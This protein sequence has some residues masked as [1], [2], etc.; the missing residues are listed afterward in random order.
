MVPWGQESG[1]RWRNRI[2]GALE[3]PKDIIVGLPKVT[4]VGYLQVTVENHR[5]IVEFSSQRVRVAAGEGVVE[6]RG[7]DL[8]LRCVLP[9]EIILDGHIEAVAFES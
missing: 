1:R 6:I 3:L 2:A 9:D 4:I 7:Q 5:G 8:T